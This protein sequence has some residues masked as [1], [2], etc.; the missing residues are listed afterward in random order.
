M[1]SIFSFALNQRLGRDS[2]ANTEDV[3]GVKK[4]L[5]S[6]GFYPIP[7]YGMTPWTDEGLF[8]GLKNF[9]K[10][11]GLTVDGF[12]KPGGPT[13]RKLNRVLGRGPRR[14]QGIIAKEES[15]WRP[16]I[17]APVNDGRGAPERAPNLLQMAQKNNRGDA[18][19]Q[20]PAQKPPLKVPPKP[21]E[22]PKSSRTASDALFARFRE[23]LR[24]REGGYADRPKTEDP[25][26]RTD[27]GISEKLLKGINARDG[28]KLP[29]DPRKLTSNQK[30]KIYKEEFFN[31]LKINKV[32]EIAGMRVQAP[33]LPEQ[34]FDAGVQH[35]PETAGTMLQKA[36][37]QHMGGELHKKDNKG[38]QTYDGLVGPQTREALTKASEEGKLGA[39]NN[40]M[41]KMRLEFMRSLPN[42]VSNK[43]GWEARAR[44]FRIRETAKP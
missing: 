25:G 13:E 18:D 42:Y 35:G 38:Q 27:E 28:S 6:L 3:L 4:R 43:N 40:T 17:F 1:S 10:A 32:A 20:T 5:N 7:K 16:M 15:D 24:P 44:S 9:Q 37:A 2:S 23:K 31:P 34:L 21:V 12:M 29:E 11:N 36:I 39:I 22:K 26:G 41:L 19:S 30:A 33:Q 14:G 8:E